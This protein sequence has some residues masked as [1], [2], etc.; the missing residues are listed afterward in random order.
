MSKKTKIHYAE[1]DRANESYPYD[2]WYRTLCGLENE[3]EVTDKIELVSCKK[4]LKSFP[5][6]KQSIED[7]INDY[8][9]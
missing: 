8:Y 7:H 4:C 2:E 1:I 6:Y 9:E 5:K 3:V